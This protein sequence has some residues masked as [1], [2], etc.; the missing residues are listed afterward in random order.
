MPALTSGRFHIQ[1]TQLAD[2]PVPMYDAYVT[3]QDKKV[4]VAGG[5]SPVVG[6][7]YL[8]YMSMMSTL[9]TGISYLHQVTIMVFLTS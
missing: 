7:E 6:S 5:N 8:V 2:L 9:I 3:I 1:W 4:Y